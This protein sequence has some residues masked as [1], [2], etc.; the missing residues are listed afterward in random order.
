[1][2]LRPVDGYRI[3]WIDAVCIDQG[4]EKEKGHQVQQMGEIYQMAERVIIWLGTG[5][6]DSDNLMEFLGTLSSNTEVHS[7]SQLV[8][9][10]LQDRYRE[11]M[12]KLLER[13]W[14][15]RV[16]IIQE[17]AKARRAIV[18]C[19]WKSVSTRVFTNAPSL[20]G[21]ELDLHSKAILD[22]MPGH[23]R[24]T[25]WYTQQPTLHTL[26]L[27]FHR[28]EATD[29]RDMIY[30]LLGMSSSVYE[31]SKLQADYTK[32]LQELIRS[33]TST[34]LFPGRTES[35][36]LYYIDWGWSEFI[37]NLK[38]LRSAAFLCALKHSTSEPERFISCRWDG[39][40]WV[41]FAVECKDIRDHPAFVIAAEYG[42]EGILKALLEQDRIDINAKDNN[43]RTPLWTAAQGGHEGIVR[44]LVEQDRIDINAKDNNGKTPLWTAA[45]GG[46]EG[47]VRLLVEQDSININ[48]KDNH[49]KTPLQVAARTGHEGVVRLLAMFGRR[50]S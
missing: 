40:K 14:F 9:H 44:L 34:L 16:W 28:S 45:Q 46:H 42:H 21:L 6:E 48:A 25:N 3:L 22:V 4:D 32:N 7:T 38:Y 43:G 13:P 26:L 18:A 8:P 2:N 50:K 5:S 11:S 39:P 17:V 36:D 27:N 19:G 33:T 20:L 30:A 10:N 24:A 15:R 12:R 23:L 29:K 35:P 47:V 37:D 49:G 41:D 1:N 31:R